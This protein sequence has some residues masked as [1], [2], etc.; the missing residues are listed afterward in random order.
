MAAITADGPEYTMRGLFR[1]LEEPLGSGRLSYEGRLGEIWKASGLDAW[2][3][4]SWNRSGSIPLP[5]QQILR[6][7]TA[8]GDASAGSDLTVS[9]I[10]RVAA[11][12]RPALVLDALGCPRVELGKVN[13]LSFPVWQEEADPGSWS[14]EGAEG[15]RLDP[16]LAGPTATGHTAIS[17]VTFT[18]RLRQSVADGSLEADV[19]A[20]MTSATRATIEQ[21]F[22]AGAGNAHE[23]HGLITRQAAGTAS[24]AAATPT[25]T[26][27]LAQLA[28]YTSAHG[29]LGQASWVCDSSMALALM[30][31]P[32]ATDSGRFLL[33][34]DSTGQ[35][36]IL[37]RPVGVTDHAP[38]GTL[39]LF[40]PASI[41]TCYWGTPFV[42]L[43]KYSDGMDIRGDYRLVLY[44]LCDIVALRP[45][46]IIV[47]SAA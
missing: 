35:P 18:R 21:G 2:E 27:L 38:A 29:R 16:T 23:P 37:G 11:A 34:P 32:A 43:D 45:E 9:G 42:L 26:E 25:R 44:N 12:A 39:T 10:A 41:R 17:W 33:E 22:L 19:L 8:D 6:A 5:N 40:D 46:Q 24:Y 4:P 30:A 15:S 1:A 28:S 36:R 14:G 20:V 47:G 7:L 13:A 31:E 3:A